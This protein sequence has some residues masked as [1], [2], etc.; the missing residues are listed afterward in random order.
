MV[1]TIEEL[2]KEYQQ[3][4]ISVKSLS[5]KYNISYVKLLKDFK[6]NGVIIRKDYS[7]L[8]R[9]YDLN[10]KYFEKIN[11]KEKAYWLGFIYADG[12]NFIKQNKV[13]IGLNSFD[14]HHLE[15]FKN[16]I[17]YDGPIYTYK[18]ISSINIYNKKLSNDL[19][20]LGC[21]N[22][23]SL[24]LEFPKYLSEK[25]YSSFIRGY[26]DGD[27]HISKNVK[28]CRVGIVG[29]E[30]FCSFIQKYIYKNLNVNSKLYTRFPDRNNST[31]DLRISGG[32]QARKFLDWI[33]Q[34]VGIVLYRKYDI[35]LSHKLYE[36]NILPNLPKTTN[37]LNTSIT[38]ITDNKTFISITEA[39]R[40]Y[41]IP[42]TSFHRELKRNPIVRGKLFKLDPKNALK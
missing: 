3:S 36:K 41:K 35:Y 4:D 2:E 12:N 10:E 16:C 24:I 32:K 13:S 31:R 8:S 34:D 39:A 5:K 11:N 15:K 7:I 14:L 42:N 20:I 40:F 17:K 22:N 19:K 25:Y 30:K 33:Y 21:V 18:N 6:N 29:T 26:L 38:C 23:K 9:K 37:P 1:K 28:K 27:G